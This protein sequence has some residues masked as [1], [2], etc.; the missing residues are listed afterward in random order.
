MS[1]PRHRRDANE[2]E[3]I[4][5]LTDA[6][7]RIMRIESP[8]D[9]EPDL[10]VGF[11]GK[12]HLLEVKVPETGR[13]SEGQKRARA[14]WANVGVFVHV[15]KTVKEAL[16]AVGIGP[17]ADT[18]RRRALGEIAANLRKKSDEFER[19]AKLVSSAHDYRGTSSWEDAHEPIPTPQNPRA[20]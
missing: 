8:D 12:L 3:M 5:V 11:L 1:R 4:R 7:A 19:R 14:E 17:Q 2:P 10:L 6:G 20:I 9:D 15:V 16:E 18:E 13:L